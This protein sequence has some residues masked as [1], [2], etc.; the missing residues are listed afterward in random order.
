MILRIYGSSSL[1]T[2]FTVTRTQNYF[3]FRQLTLKT[4]KKYGFFDYRTKQLG[5]SGILL[6]IAYKDLDDDEENITFAPTSFAAKK[7]FKDQFTFIL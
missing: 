1:V 5:K 2:I 7:T 6:I 4:L 3:K